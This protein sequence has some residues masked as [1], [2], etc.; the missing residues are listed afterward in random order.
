MATPSRRDLLRLFG[1]GLSVLTFPI[2]APAEG[3]VATAQRYCD[4]ALTMLKNGHWYQ[5]AV[6]KLSYCVSQSPAT[7]AY[8]LAL[9]CAQASLLAS[10]CAALRNRERR[11]FS[12]EEI[13]AFLEQHK[14]NS[15]DGSPPTREDIRVFF[16]SPEADGKATVLV[17]SDESLLKK[18]RGLASGAGESWKTAVSL[19]HTEAQK[20][21]ALTTQVWGLKLLIIIYGS[22]SSEGISATF[23][24]K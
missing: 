7:P 16:P 3:D 1:T 20:K 11:K 6:D 8:H 17:Y 9:G 15:P 14:E 19:S 10:H 13:K 23:S 22:L 24:E 21:E 5:R 4:D 12:P 2:A 18:L